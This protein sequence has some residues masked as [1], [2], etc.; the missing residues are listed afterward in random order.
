MTRPRN[1]VA[2]RR[3]DPST[4]PRES[5]GV[6]FTLSVAV[7]GAILGLAACSAPA[8]RQSVARP[9]AP[10]QAPQ[11]PERRAAS[12]DERFEAAL[13]LMKDQQPQEAQRAFLELA[14]D[15]PDLSGALTNLGILYARSRERDAAIAFFAKAI[16]ANPG[17]AVALNWLGILYRENGDY[18]SA[19]NAYRRALAVR[20]DYAAAHLNLG[21]LYDVFMQ[22]PR[23]ALAEYRSY[24]MQAGTQDLI[25][26]AW[27]MDLASKVG[28]QT[29]SRE[30]ASP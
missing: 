6:V 26:G 28:T 25:V 10:L 20:P 24:Q 23:D 21:I 11:L 1:D 17:N 18:R 19:E 14:R 9:S 16:D 7:T 27:I 29:A 4:E 3:F 13:K 12:A 30:G 22:R 15:Y 8:P 2:Q 5:A